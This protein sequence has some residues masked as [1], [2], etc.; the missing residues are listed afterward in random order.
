VKRSKVE[1]VYKKQCSLEISEAC[2][3][4]ID[5]GELIDTKLMQGVFEYSIDL[6]YGILDHF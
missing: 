6:Y 2:K 3:V 5:E 1:R 4:R